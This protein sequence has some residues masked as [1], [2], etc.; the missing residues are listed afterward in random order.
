MIGIIAKLVCT[1][2]HIMRIYATSIMKFLGK[3]A[4]FSTC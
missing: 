1:K 2:P 3:N 4:K